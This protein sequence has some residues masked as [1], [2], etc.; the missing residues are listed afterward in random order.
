M[1]TRLRWYVYVAMAPYLSRYFATEHEAVSYHDD[2]VGMGMSA[3]ITESC[4]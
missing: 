1:T 4:P 3:T 2:V